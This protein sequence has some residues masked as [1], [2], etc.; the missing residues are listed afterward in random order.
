[1]SYNLPEEPPV[2]PLTENV[3]VIPQDLESEYREGE[4]LKPRFHTKHG[5]NH[6][7]YG[8]VVDW[9][10]G[11]PD[12][13]RR[14][15]NRDYEESKQSYWSFSQVAE[16]LKTVVGFSQG[17]ILK[18]EGMG[19]KKEYGLVKVQNLILA[20]DYDSHNF[21][22]SKDAESFFAEDGDF[23]ATGSL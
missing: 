16:P 14:L 6:L 17:R 8:L 1:M 21:V 10:N 9:G 13:F 4:I 7:L 23:T 22:D 2:E 20:M 12:S 5:H 19:G 3:L 15:D 11:I 18:L